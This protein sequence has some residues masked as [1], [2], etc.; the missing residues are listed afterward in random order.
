CSNPADS[1]T[2]ANGFAT[3]IQRV[4]LKDLADLRVSMFQGAIFCTSS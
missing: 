1:Q 4:F 3:C 2:K